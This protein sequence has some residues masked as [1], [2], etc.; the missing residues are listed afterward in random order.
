MLHVWKL[1]DMA[2]RNADFCHRCKGNS[3]SS[4]FNPRNLPAPGWSWPACSPTYCWQASAFPSSTPSPSFS[5]PPSTAATW[6]SGWAGAAPGSCCTRASRAWPSGP[7]W[8]SRWPPSPPCRGSRRR[9][10]GQRRGGE[11]NDVAP[12][13]S[14]IFNFQ[15]I[16]LVQR[17][18]IA[19]NGKQQKGFHFLGKV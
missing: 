14:S 7:T 8:S 6:A 5:S 2:E 11:G 3:F 19:S 4:P 10:L 15:I 13:G 1:N 17:K 12:P 9:T 18:K 16:L